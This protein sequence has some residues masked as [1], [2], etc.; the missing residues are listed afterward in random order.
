MEVWKKVNGFEHI[1]VSDQGRL[2]NDMSGRIYKPTINKQGYCVITG[3]DRKQYKMH[4]LVAMA[5]PEICGEYKDGLQVDH[6]NTI[7]T[8]NRAENLHWC[9]CKENC[10]N[11]LTSQKRSEYMRMNNP[12]KNPDV[13]KKVSDVM[14][15]RKLS[16]EHKKKIGDFQRGKIL[17]EE[18]KQRMS[19]AST[20]RQR[21]ERGMFV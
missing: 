3:P 2:R 10:N 14:I 7:R 6:I 15:G 9:S 16:D 21:D 19:I 13:A 12:M 1:S 20:R 8:D 11:P 4:R 17:S 5:F 18:T